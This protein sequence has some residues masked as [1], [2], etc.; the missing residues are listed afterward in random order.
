ME[1]DADVTPR[2]PSVRVCVCD[3]PVIT[4]PVVTL[5]NATLPDSNDVLAGLASVRIVLTEPR[6]VPLKFSGLTRTSDACADSAA[7]TSIAAPAIGPSLVLKSS[8]VP[9]VTTRP[10]HGGMPSGRSLVEARPIPATRPGSATRGSAGLAARSSVDWGDLEAL[11]FFQR[12][13]AIDGNE[14]GRTRLMSCVSV[15]QRQ[16]A[17]RLR[18]L[19]T[20]AARSARRTRR[21]LASA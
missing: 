14:G 10:A 12:R 21:R 18:A 6:P 7:S 20:A 8:I 5:P 11:K 15:T 19:L 17:R 16:Q 4:L 2:S 9:P 13:G 1:F 3:A